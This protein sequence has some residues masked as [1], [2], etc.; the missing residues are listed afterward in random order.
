MFKVHLAPK[1]KESSIDNSNQIQKS[2]DNDDA[3]E[4]D[5]GK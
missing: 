3:C 1:K 5:Q 2:V 4:C